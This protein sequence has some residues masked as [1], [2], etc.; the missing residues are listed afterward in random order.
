[1]KSGRKLGTIFLSIM[2]AAG[3]SGQPSADDTKFSILELQPYGYSADDG[4]S[5]GYLYEFGRAVFLDAGFN[6]DNV[7]LTPLKRLIRD[8]NNGAEDC[9]FLAQTPYV[10]SHYVMVEDLEIFIDVGVVPKRGI[11]L[12]TYEDLAGLRIAIPH[13]AKILDRFDNDDTLQKINSADYK[14]SVVLL[15]RGRVDAMAGAYGSLLFNMRE[16]G[17]S[18][19]TLIDRPLIFSRL[20][21]SLVCRAEI[22]GSALATQLSTSIIKLRDQGVLK[23]IVAKYLGPDNSDYVN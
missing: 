23:S 14:N 16:L 12:E 17:L 18:P 20:S 6:P 13:G 4:S 15:D 2:M 3:L 22:V 7:R 11:T 1:M 9:T 21:M 10:K 8:M 5:K 19:N